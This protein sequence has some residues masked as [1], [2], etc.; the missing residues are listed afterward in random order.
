MLV[1][2]QTAPQQPIRR[3]LLP[4]QSDPDLRGAWLNWQTALDGL[5]RDYSASGSDLTPVGGPTTLARAGAHFTAASSQYL[6]RAEADW[7]SGDSVGTI[8]AWIK[9]D[10]VGADQTIFCSGDEGSVNHYLRLQ[11]DGTNV[12]QILQHDGTT[13]NS[14]L[15]T[16][17]TFVAD[18]WYHIVLVST[19]SEY[20]VYIDRRLETLNVAS[21][22][23]D[24]DWL[25]DASSRDNVT[26][27]AQVINITIR[28]FDGSIL[29]CRYYSRVLSPSEILAQYQAG[30][31]DDS[32]VGSWFDSGVDKSRFG[33]DLAGVNG[34]T[35][36]HDM[37]FV[38]ASSQYLY[39]STANWRSGDS[40]GTIMAWIKLDAVTNFQKIWSSSDEGSTT[41]YLFLGFDNA[42]HLS[43]AQRNNDVQDAVV[44][45]TVFVANRWYHVAV[46]S[47]GSSYSLYVDG[48]AESLSVDSGGNFGHW[49]DVT[50]SR[51]NITLAVWESDLARGYFNGSIRKVEVFSEAKAAEFIARR[52]DAERKFF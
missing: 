26:I 11:I 7:N 29:D 21:G 6:R 19:G 22:A 3:A 14:L 36:G 32:L 31:P 50:L 5:G 40:A 43:I 45:A 12:I 20:L 4:R 1:P 46:S 27:G 16:D 15:G 39:K 13:L 23:N 48:V 30:V 35:V 17:T 25:N 41:R 42:G 49:L 24:G 10:S 52:Y 18:R 38:S 51:D 44:G 47:N 28:Y 34:P 9:L 8:S 37:E 33:L 2:I